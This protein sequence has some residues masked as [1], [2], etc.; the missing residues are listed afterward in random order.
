[1]NVRLIFAAAT[2]VIL[3]ACTNVAPS[4]GSGQAVP[5]GGPTSA[6]GAGSSSPAGAAGTIV[7][8]FSLHSTRHTEEDTI[9]HVTDES[10][11]LTVDA[12]LVRDSA[13]DG[14]VYVDDG[15][16]YA[17]KALRTSEQQLG[18]C[19][20]TSEMVA[21]AA[22]AFS[23]QPTSYENSIEITVDRAQGTA[24]IN[25][26]YS[27]IYDVTG[28]ACAAIEPRSDENAAGLACP[29]FPLTAKLIEG[30]GSDQI[31]TTCVLPGGET[32]SGTLTLTR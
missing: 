30:D 11:D 7:G 29:F 19:L 6:A 12:R 25:A 22:Y 16:R 15:S 23:D 1:M 10:F 2:C 27:W 4:G 26:S 32:Y 31:D 17:V 28:N 14:E 5:G 13:A 24:T 3:A 8:T 9:H 20:A 21:D 18:D